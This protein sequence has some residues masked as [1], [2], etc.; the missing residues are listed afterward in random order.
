MTMNF[1]I[2]YKSNVFYVPHYINGTEINLGNWQ[3][4]TTYIA[5]TQSSNNNII[6]YLYK[7][8]INDI[9]LFHQNHHTLP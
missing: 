7:S 4:Y 3:F 6:V 8:Y 5:N 2:S 1:T 9:M